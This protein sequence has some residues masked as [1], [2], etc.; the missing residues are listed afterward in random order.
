MMKIMDLRKSS[1]IVV[2]E[3]GKGWFASRAVFML[4]AFGHPRAFILDGGLIKWCQE[5][6]ATVTAETEDYDAD[7]DYDLNS[8]NL[9]SFERV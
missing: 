1:T 6:R 4:R 9:V 3:S 5:E 2:Y 8:D 7:F